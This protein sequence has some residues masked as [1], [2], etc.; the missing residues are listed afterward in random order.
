[1]KY[2]ISFFFLLGCS[3]PEKN[4]PPVAGTGCAE[5]C[6]DTST[7]STDTGSTSSSVGEC[8]AYIGCMQQCKTG[9]CVAL[10]AEAT[11]SDA[12]VCEELRCDGLTDACAQGD[13]QACADVLSC[14]HSASSEESSS[15]SETSGSS[16]TS[17]TSGATTEDSSSSGG[18]G[19][20][21]SSSSTG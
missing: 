18:S 5:E 6:T 10:C 1:M 13:M 7:T 12:D 19:T 11:S 4:Y 3:V 20:S 16:S 15:T 14:V 8:D 9:D 17:E 21:D 2:A